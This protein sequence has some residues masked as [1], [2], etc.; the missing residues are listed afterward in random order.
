MQRLSS[1]RNNLNENVSTTSLESS[2]FYPFLHKQ[3]STMETTVLAFESCICSRDRMLRP[4]LIQR[5]QYQSR[6]RWNIQWLFVGIAHGM[7]CVNPPAQL[8]SKWL[9]SCRRLSTAKFGLVEKIYPLLAPRHT[10]REAVID[11]LRT[12]LFRKQSNKTAVG[13][14][15][16]T[17]E[18]VSIYF[19]HFVNVGLASHWV[20]VVGNR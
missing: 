9:S 17:N 2:I 13:S 11:R 5:T 4:V 18:L 16:S 3:F 20:E 12:L 6:R 15:S 1:T 14:M 7:L 19:D 10:F 8:S